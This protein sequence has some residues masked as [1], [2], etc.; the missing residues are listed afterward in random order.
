VGAL[1]RFGEYA[2]AFERSYASDDW[3]HVEPF[4]HEDAVYVVGLPSGMGGTFEGRDAILAYFKDVLDGF[5]RR[6]A[7]RTVSAEAPPTEDGDTVRLLGRAS[8]T[9]D[10]APDLS[11]VLEEIVTFDGDRIRRLED[12]YEAADREIV[13]AYVAA[14][15]ETLGLG[16]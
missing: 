11:F 8:Y 16:L 2:A 15:G 12:R 13:E 4:F 5:D 14:H 3:S 6:F 1:Q 10:G 7:S 9:A